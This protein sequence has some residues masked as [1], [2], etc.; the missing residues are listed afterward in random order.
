M[1]RVLK[2]APAPGRLS[3]L[4]KHTMRQLKIH[5]IEYKPQGYNL[6]DL[7][8]IEQKILLPKG[9]ALK[10]VSK[11]FGDSVI[12]DGVKE[13]KEFKASKLPTLQAIDEAIWESEGTHFYDDADLQEY[14]EQGITVPLN[15]TSDFFEEHQIEDTDDSPPPILFPERNV[16]ISDKSK[17]TEKE[18]E[19]EPDENEEGD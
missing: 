15:P 2:K 7:K 14:D 5:G 9:Y 8:V 18:N 19:E 17:A 11:D 10:I 12:Y 13:A 4:H 3:L 1:R 6:N 16:N